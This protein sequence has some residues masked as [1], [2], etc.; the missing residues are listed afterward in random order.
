MLFFASGLLPVLA[1]TELCQLWKWPWWL[2]CC[3]PTPHTTKLVAF[4]ANSGVFSKCWQNVGSGVFKNIAIHGEPRPCSPPRAVCAQRSWEAYVINAQINKKYQKISTPKKNGP[5][6][7]CGSTKD[8]SRK[9]G[10]NFH[11][12]SHLVTM[13]KARCHIASA[14][15]DQHGGFH[16]DPL[17][18]ALT[19]NWHR[20]HF[21]SLS[22]QTQ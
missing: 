8:I 2:V 11:I 14:T 19:G 5:N 1:L 17:L 13:A 3:R 12:F 9:N 15:C 21:A 7:N 4:F 20:P 10:D 16:L 6:P 22:V 18:S